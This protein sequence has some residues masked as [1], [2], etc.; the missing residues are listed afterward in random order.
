[1]KNIH[2][3]EAL[4]LKSNRRRLYQSAH[5]LPNGTLTFVDFNCTDGTETALAIV[6]GAATADDPRLS[7]NLPTHR[8]RSFLATPMTALDYTAIDAPD[9]EQIDATSADA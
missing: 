2:V 7:G 9:D 6:T 4:N 5:D 1:M 8:V 3:I